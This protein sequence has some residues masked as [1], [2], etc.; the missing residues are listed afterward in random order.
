[1]TGA[2]GAADPVPDPEPDPVPGRGFEVL[3]AGPL[4]TVQ[5]T[6][7]P[8]LGHVGVGRSG[9]CDLP[10][11][12]LANRLVGNPEAAATLE[13]TLGGLVVRWSRSAWVA[14]TGAVADADVDGT[15]VPFHAPFF[16]AAGAVLSVGVPAAGLR[17][18]LG[19]SGGVAVEPVLGSRSTDVLADLG[20]APLRPGDRVPLGPSTMRVGAGVDVVPV[21]PVPGLPVLDVL[22]GPRLDWFVPTALAELAATTWTVGSDS[23]RVGVRLEGPALRRVRDD[24]LPSEGVVEGAVQVPTSGQP[25]LFLADHPVTGGYP[26]LAVLTAGALAAAAQ[27]RP[28]QQVRLRP[29]P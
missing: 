4:T 18:Y 22:P 7:R 20:P 8:G 10:A 16:V 1:M 23:N 11:H 27:L 21:R 29:V 2:R 12:R 14:L 26:V 25:V 13:L 19:V 17:S 5:D 24:E 9:A 28:G 3:A 6:G 15:P